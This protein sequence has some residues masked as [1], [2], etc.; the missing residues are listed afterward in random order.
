[1]VD[2]AIDE[3]MA[4]LTGSVRHGPVRVIDVGTG[5]GAI[6]I[7]L[8]VA[9]RKRRVPPED[10]ELLATD[11]SPDALD[12]ARENAVSHGVGDR[13]SFR[14]ADLLPPET[15]SASWEVIL[16]NLP[17]VRS[18]VVDSLIEQHASPAFE[19]RRALDGGQ[20]GLSEIG[21]LLDEL[22]RGLAEDGVALLEIGSD[23]GETIRE[24]TASRLPGWRLEVI[25]DL[26]GL[27]RVARIEREGA[28]RASHSR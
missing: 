14:A 24:L 28:P 2:R 13:V 25:A 5:S 4:R 20:D 19:P 8:A 7:A 16:A 3:V 18:A 15:F 6:A 27:P 1:L 23:Q 17:Y 10:V 12:L 11:I 26:A 21:R 9:L 22:P